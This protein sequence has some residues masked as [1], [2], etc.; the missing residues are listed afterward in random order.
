MNLLEAVNSGKKF[1]RQSFINDGE[2]EYFSSDD[3]VSSMEVEDVTAEDYVLL[4]EVLDESLMADVWNR[5]KSSSTPDASQSKFFRK[6]V[7]EL[8]HKGFVKVG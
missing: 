6:L 4:P 7:T 3:F 2:V 8:Q 5:L 1:T